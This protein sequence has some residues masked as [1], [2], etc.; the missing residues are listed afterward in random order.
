MLGWWFGAGRILLGVG[1]GCGGFMLGMGCR[2]CLVLLLLSFLGPYKAI[3]CMGTMLRLFGAGALA[4]VDLCAIERL[5]SVILLF[6]YY[7]YG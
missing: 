4:L 7:M 3:R 1:K 6:H 2:L 5:L